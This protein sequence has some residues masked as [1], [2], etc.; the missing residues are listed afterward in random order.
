MSY[1]VAI[2]ENIFSNKK[3]NVEKLKVY[4]FIQKENTWV[5]TTPLVE[6]FTITVKISNS[7]VTTVVK[8][9]E[10]NKPINLILFI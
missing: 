4:G 1:Q 8:D 10:T 6:N 3:P 7:K 2:V 9:Q 5:Y